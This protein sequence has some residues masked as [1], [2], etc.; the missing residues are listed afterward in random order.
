MYHQSILLNDGRVLTVGGYS[1]GTGDVLSNSE[2]YDPITKVS[3]EVA[4]LEVP[5][6]FYTLTKLSNG[7]IMILGGSKTILGSGENSIEFLIQLPIHGVD[8]ALILHLLERVI[9]QRY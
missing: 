9:H 8:I 3:T 7:K 4:P 5:R 6:V 2:V 1:M